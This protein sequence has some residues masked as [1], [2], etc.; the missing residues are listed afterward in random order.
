[1]KNKRKNLVFVFL[2]LILPLCFLFVT[3]AQSYTWETVKVFTGTNDVTTATFT[4][5]EDARFVWTTTT[6]Y[7]EYDAFAVFVYPQ[8]ETNMYETEFEGV[9]GTSY[10]YAEG[11]FYMVVLT[12]NLNS[13][14]IEVQQKDFGSPATNGDT[15]LS[16]TEI[17]IG[18]VAFV[19][20]AGGITAYILVRRKRATKVQDSQVPLQT[21]TQPPT[22][23]PV[24]KLK[25]CTQCGGQ[26]E[27]STDFCIKCGQKFE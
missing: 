20:V 3:N 1:M 10:L 13:W 4:V 17:I 18:A 15:E 9:S 16:P 2:F 25:F 6:S 14:R 24:Q 21:A 7:P 23:T 8:G 22:E 26:N 12:A 19:V 27:L 11:T 5:T